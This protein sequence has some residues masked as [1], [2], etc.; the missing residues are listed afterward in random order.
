MVSFMI[1]VT[2]DKATGQE[3]TADSVMTDDEGKASVEFILGS[4]KGKYVVSRTTGTGTKSS[5]ALRRLSAQE[6]IMTVGPKEPHPKKNPTVKTVLSKMSNDQRAM[7]NALDLERFRSS[8]V[9]RKS[10]YFFFWYE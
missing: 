7:Y 1:I 8:Q 3:I 9:T 4:K 10:G 5:V 6:G 2:P